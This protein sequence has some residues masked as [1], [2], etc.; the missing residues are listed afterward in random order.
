MGAQPA[1]T[2]GGSVKPVTSH[3]TTTDATAIPASTAHA[4]T[5]ERKHLAGASDAR[6]DLNPSGGP[7]VTVSSAAPLTAGAVAA[8]LHEAGY[9][10]LMR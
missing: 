9:Y 4:V 7:A 1:D 5:G 6:A 3:T 10:Q 2:P 8:V